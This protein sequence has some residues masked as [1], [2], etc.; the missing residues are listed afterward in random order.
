MASFDV[1]LECIFRAFFFLAIV[2]WHIWNI[3]HYQIRSQQCY[4]TEFKFQ[5]FSLNQITDIREEIKFS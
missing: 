1:P 2:E 5:F 3:G 4:T